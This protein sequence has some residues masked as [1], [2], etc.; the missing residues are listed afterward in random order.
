MSSIA[1]THSSEQKQD[2]EDTSVSQYMSFIINERSYAIPLSQVAEITPYQELN[3]MP[4]TP[5]GVEGLLDLRGSVLPVVSLRTRMGLPKKEKHET[6]HIL[7]LSHEGSR[8]GVLVDQVESVITATAEQHVDASPMLEGTDGTWV[9]GVLLRNDKVILV[10]EPYSLAKLSQSENPLVRSTI[11][12]ADGAD[13]ELMLDE[14]LHK[15]IAMAGP[16]EDGKV[17]SQMENAISHT[18]SEMTKVLDSVESMLTSSD[19]ALAGISRFKQEVAMNGMKGFDEGLDSLG[20]VTQEVQDGIFDVIQQLQ[21]QDIV[22]QKL[23][24]VLRHIVGMDKI[25]SLGLD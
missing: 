16:K 25:I 9:R 18:E 6:D 7:I 15:L 10:L 19:S 11:P 4:H 14:S 17:V 13:V 8:T 12:A 24:R 20:K 22:R 1:G 3:Q 5:K 21:F 23:E 2:A